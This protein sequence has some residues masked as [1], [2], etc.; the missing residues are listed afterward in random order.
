MSTSR[1]TGVFRCLP[2]AAGADRDTGGAGPE[3]RI[4]EPDGDLA[5]DFAGR[6]GGFAQ[7]RRL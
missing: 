3:D 6:V 2:D 1:P 4:A 7:D 5:G